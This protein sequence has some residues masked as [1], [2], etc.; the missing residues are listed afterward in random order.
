MKP[1]AKSKES[2]EGKTTSAADD[3]VASGSAGQG[4]G[5]KKGKTKKK[6]ADS[7]GVKVAADNPDGGPDGEKD[8]SV[9][10]YP[11][12]FAGR[13]RPRGEFLAHKWKAKYL[14]FQNVVSPA[15]VGTGASKLQVPGPTLGIVDSLQ[16]RIDLMH[17]SFDF[18]ACS[19]KQRLKLE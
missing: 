13:Y 10:E 1:V 8:D 16:S 7:E 15:F 6:P 4:E 9:T 19:L 18:L 2:K 12:T 17:Y 5:Q 11:K 3:A 14:A